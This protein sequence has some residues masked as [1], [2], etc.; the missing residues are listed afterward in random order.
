MPGQDHAQRLSERTSANRDDTA[1]GERT[2]K[3]ERKPP[4][5]KDKSRYLLSGL[6]K[7]IKIAQDT[8]WNGI[9]AVEGEAIASLVEQLEKERKP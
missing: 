8:P 7:L 1:D 5:E 3:D 9:T 2:A 6:K 4:M